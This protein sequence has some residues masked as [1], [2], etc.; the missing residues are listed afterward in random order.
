MCFFLLVSLLLHEVRTLKGILS[1]SSRYERGTVVASRSSKPIRAASS[2]TLLRGQDQDDDNDVIG[3]LRRDSSKTK[4]RPLPNLPTLHPP[5]APPTNTP[6]PSPPPTIPPTGLPTYSYDAT[7]RPEHFIDGSASNMNV[8][9]EADTPFLKSTETAKAN[10]PFDVSRIY[11]IVRLYAWS[12]PPANTRAVALGSRG[13][14]R[15]DYPA[16]AQA[17]RNRSISIVNIQPSQSGHNR[18]PK[19]QDWDVF[20]CVS[21]STDDCLGKRDFL[22]YSRERRKKVNRIYGLRKTLWNKDAFC[23]TVTSSLGARVGDYTFPC[24]VLPRDLESFR[25]VAK[26]NPQASWIAKPAAQGGGKGIYLIEGLDATALKHFQK[27]YT[28]TTVVQPYLPNPHLVAGKKWDLRTYVLVTSVLPMRAYV[29]SRGLVRF[30]TQEHGKKSRKAFLTNTSINKKNGTA[31][32]AITWPFSRLRS[33][34]G[35]AEYDRV[36]SRMESAIRMV[37]VG[38]ETS[39][40]NI[41]NKRVSP[42]FRCGNCYH[43][44]GVDLILDD[45]M[46]PRVIEVNGEPSMVLEGRPISDSETNHYDETKMKMQRD[47]VGLVLSTDVKRAGE[48]T[49]EGLRADDAWIDENELK[50]IVETNREGEKLGGWRP[51]YPSARMG[52]AD[53]IFA[54]RR[55]RF[56]DLLKRAIRIDAEDK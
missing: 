40:E 5:S 2:R 15:R 45:A 54:G 51:V 12:T 14:I 6:P 33:H 24:W 37:L 31:A 56:H 39:F 17:F 3:L 46:V 47:A 19:R 4:K 36:F 30:A 13:I 7:F 52:D 26:R 1:K 28:K 29:Y 11:S 18:H 32:S 38:S 21:L 9:I 8:N 44:F 34:L 53:W 43:L 55:K 23:R 35:A 22:K 20:V 25:G 50:Y 16:I 10:A 49:V 27:K 42:G 41:F 48:R